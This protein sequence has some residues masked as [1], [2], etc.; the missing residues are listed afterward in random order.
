M[1]KAYL[2]AFEKAVN[3]E[4]KGNITD[5]PKENYLKSKRKGKSA[6]ENLAQ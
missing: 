6:C 1:L 5:K 3:A 4:G 2:D